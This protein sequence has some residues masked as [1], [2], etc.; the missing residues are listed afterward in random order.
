MSNKGVMKR[1]LS[2]SGVSGVTI[3]NCIVTPDFGDVVLCNRA[4]YETGF[5]LSRGVRGL[6]PA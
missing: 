6:G 4:G 2:F 3:Y 5:E 1:D